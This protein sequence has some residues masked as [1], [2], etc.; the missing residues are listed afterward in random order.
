M[1][2]RGT[3]ELGWRQRRGH[4]E[5][6]ADVDMKGLHENL[7]GASGGML[8]DEHCGEHRHVLIPHVAHIEVD[9]RRSVVPTACS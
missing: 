6:M 2:S 8:L 3:E 4:L 1:I 7:V 5:V 9:P